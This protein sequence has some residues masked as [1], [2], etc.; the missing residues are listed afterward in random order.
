[1]KKKVKDLPEQYKDMIVKMNSQLKSNKKKL[2]QI[3]EQNDKL[4]NTLEN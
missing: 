3:K 1:M 2:D 4:K